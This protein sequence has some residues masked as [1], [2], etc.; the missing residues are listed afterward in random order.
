MRPATT[1][2]RGEPAPGGSPVPVDRRAGLAAAGAGLM[3]G[4]LADAQP[5]Q[6]ATAV[7]RPL[8]PLSAAW[9]A[10]ETLPLWHGAPPETGFRPQVVPPDAPPGFLRNVATPMLHVFRPRVANKA[11]ILRRR[12][13]RAATPFSCWSIGCPAKAGAIALLSRCRMRSARCA[14]FA[15]MRS[16]TRSTPPGSL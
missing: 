11:A 7:S 4:A 16:V 12:L 14:L 6:A 1:I 5:G 3:L 8:G 13:P 10:A 9:R 2:A 15:P